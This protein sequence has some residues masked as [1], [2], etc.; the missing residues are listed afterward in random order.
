LDLGHE[1]NE[2]VAEYPGRLWQG[3]P[4]IGYRISQLQSIYVNPAT[5]LSE[6][7]QGKFPQDF[8]NSRLAQA[9]IDAAN[10]LD[11]AHV[12]ALCGNHG[13]EFTLAKGEVAIGADIGPVVHHVVVAR[14][15]YSGTY[16]VIWLGELDWGG[17]D[18]LME[19]YR[20]CMVV[21]G[22]PEPARVLELGKR[23]PYRIFGC[24]YSQSASLVKHWDE[25]DCKIVVYQAQAMDSS[26]QVL[27]RG[28]VLLPRASLDEVKLFAQHCHNVA[29][30]K[31][32]DEE[33]GAVKY[34]WIKMG[35]DHYRK[36]FNFMI[37]AG[38]RVGTSVQGAAN[39]YKYLTTVGIARSYG[40]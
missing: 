10:R 4:A 17:L 28:Q 23:H 27:Q 37:L 15:E 24:F 18:M 8:Y 9:W 19:R 6:Y 11:A 12:L 33:T 40:H 30:R 3:K 25:T 16:R 22:M 35:E 31:V 26:H 13:L 5:I 20:G 2:Y 1:R 34:Q 38:E 32:E 29:R 39:D 36:A 21:D 14:K 7:K